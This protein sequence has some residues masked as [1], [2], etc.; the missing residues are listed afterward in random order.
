MKDDDT[1]IETLLEGNDSELLRMANRGGLAI[2]T[3]YSFAVC[4]FALQLYSVV[5]AEEEIKKIIIPT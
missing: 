5:S 1:S 4:T 2:P 3:N